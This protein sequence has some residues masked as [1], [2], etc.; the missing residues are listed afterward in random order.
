MF[1]GM[2]S[3][4]DSAYAILHAAFLAGPLELL[5]GM[6]SKKPPSFVQLSA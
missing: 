5:P 6:L 1:V 2:L 3:R 4:L